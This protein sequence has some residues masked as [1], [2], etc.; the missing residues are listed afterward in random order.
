M[1]GTPWSLIIATKSGTG[2]GGGGGPRVPDGQSFRRKRAI[3]SA[4]SVVEWKRFATRFNI[5]TL[6]NGV[7]GGR[8]RVRKRNW[9]DGGDVA[10]CPFVTAVRTELLLTYTS[11]GDRNAPPAQS[12]GILRGEKNKTLSVALLEVDPLFVRPT[13]T[14]ECLWPIRK[15]ITNNIGNA[16]WKCVNRRANCRA[17]EFQN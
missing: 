9:N 1:V 13:A 10:Q 4:S 2:I 3:K 11:D 7:S 16:I 6:R 8:R 17:A 12:R 15:L 5:T 14:D